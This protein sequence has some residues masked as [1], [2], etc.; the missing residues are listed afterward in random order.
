MSSL[1]DTSTLQC[2]ALYVRFMAVDA[3]RH[4]NERTQALQC[5]R[6]VGD[7]PLQNAQEPLIPHIPDIKSLKVKPNSHQR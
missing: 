7:F 5:F 4:N 1:E 2:C 6:E 3:N